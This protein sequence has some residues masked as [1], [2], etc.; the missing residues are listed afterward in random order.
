[1][2][3]KY[4]KPIDE[5]C[6]IGVVA[7]ADE[8]DRHVAAHPVVDVLLVAEKLEARIALAREALAG[9]DLRAEVGAE[10]LFRLGVAQFDVAVNASVEA[11]RPPDRGLP[12]RRGRL[13]G[14]RRA[15]PR[16]GSRRGLGGRATA[17]P[18]R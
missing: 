12:R 13:P 2:S 3:P 10:H 18:S 17:P 5:P 7:H 6:V 15:L 9:L 14:D 16:A 8:H 4:T 11:A 1:M